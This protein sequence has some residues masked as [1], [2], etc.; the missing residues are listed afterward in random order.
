MAE[1]QQPAVAEPPG[2]LTEQLLRF[3]STLT[4]VDIGPDDDYFALGLV[5]SLRALEIV[6]HV[7][8]AYG[9]SVEIDDLD[10]D[11]FRT[12]TRIAEFVARK[13]RRAADASGER[14]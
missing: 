10:L 5:N 6:T 1:G 2:E 12:V 14:R 9:I 13:Q 3:F 11:N 8:H 4:S 7:E